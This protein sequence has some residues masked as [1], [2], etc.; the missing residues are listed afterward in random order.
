MKIDIDMLHTTVDVFVGTK[1]WRAFARKCEE[2]GR[3]GENVLHDELL[4]R[5]YDHVMWLR[6]IRKTPVGIGRV[7]HEIS[8]L[9]DR[10][11]GKRG[12]HVDGEAVAYL[13]EFLMKEVYRKFSR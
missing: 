6:E 5:C 4:G 12:L 7:A 8:H 2:E 3:E 1:Q 9:V 13:T 10:V 11:A